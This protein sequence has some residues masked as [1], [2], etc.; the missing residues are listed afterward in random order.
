MHSHIKPLL[1]IQQLK[2]PIQANGPFR[3][4]VRMICRNLLPTVIALVFSMTLTPETRA[5]GMSDT[6]INSDT[7]WLPWIGSWRLVSNTVNTSDSELT[8]EYILTVSPG[9]DV[10]SVTMKGY[11]DGIV[12]SEENITADGLRHSL[13][14]DGCTGWYLH[15]WSETGRRLL[16]NSES[17]CEEDLPRLISGMSIFDDIGEWLEIRLLKSGEEKAI[18]ISRYRNVEGDQVIP[19]SVNATDPVF[20]RI[21]AGTSL[22]ISEVIELSSKVEPEVLEA[23]LME[24]H[25]PFPIDS[26]QLARLADSEVPSQIVDLMVALSFPDK[27]TVERTTIST[28]KETA[29]PKSYTD[30]RPP[31]RYWPYGHPPYSWHWGSHIYSHYDHWYFGWNTW[32]EW[33]YPYRI[34]PYY[35]GTVKDTSRL[36]EGSGYTRINPADTGSSTRYARPRNTQQEGSATASRPASGSYYGTSSSGYSSGYSSGSSSGSSSNS[37][38]ASPNGYSSGDCEY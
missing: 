37:P 23:A 33:Y 31:Y 7:R 36:I 15:S 30:L 1:L 11:R 32:P 13:T 17:S 20:A 35:G 8:E 28:V 12:I 22:S 25:E 19:G 9:D 2:S 16:L 34:Y 4:A 21:S 6:G 14:D 29:P 38:C 18:T 26:K 5:S 24:L 27:F 3:T 10:N